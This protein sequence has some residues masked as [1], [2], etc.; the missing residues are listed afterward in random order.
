MS[1]NLGKIIKDQEIWVKVIDGSNVAGYYKNSNIED[2]IFQGG[3]IKSGRKY[4]TVKFDE[5]KE[6]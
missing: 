2:R 5:G 4:I 1:R 6:E 3:V